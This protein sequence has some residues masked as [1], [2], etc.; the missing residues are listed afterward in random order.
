MT[1][2][3]R[4]ILFGLIAVLLLAACAQN[5]KTKNPKKDELGF[6]ICGEPDVGF[7]PTTGWGQ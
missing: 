3:F 7:D 4:N 6:A 2:Q 5:K 1:K